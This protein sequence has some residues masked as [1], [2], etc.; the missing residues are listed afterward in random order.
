MHKVFYLTFILF[1][2]K[3]I[4]II[5]NLFPISFLFNVPISCRLIKFILIPLKTSERFDVLDGR[6]AAPDRF[7]R[8]KFLGALSFEKKIFRYCECA[9]SECQKRDRRHS[10]IGVS[11][12]GEKKRNECEVTTFLVHRI[13]T[14]GCEAVCGANEWP[15]LKATGLNETL[16]FSICRL[17]LIAASHNSIVNLAR[18]LDFAT[19]GTA[20]PGFSSIL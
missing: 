16:P 20:T 6:I 4:E 19:S 1:I 14:S 8:I 13:F 18:R 11:Q 9:N 17:F 5:R 15:G 12:E 7:N 2:I 3:S 10:V